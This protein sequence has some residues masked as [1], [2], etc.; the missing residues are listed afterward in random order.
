MRGMGGGKGGGKGE[1]AEVVMKG[2][3]CF[4]SPSGGAATGTQLGFVPLGV[5]IVDL[6]ADRLLVETVDTN[7]LL[8]IANKSK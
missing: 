1:A 5:V 4:W 8:R 2:N 7:K 6:L 3:N